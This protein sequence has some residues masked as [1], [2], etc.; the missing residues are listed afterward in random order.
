VRYVRVWLFF[1]KTAIIRTLEFR[2]DF[3]AWTIINLLWMVFQLTFYWVIYQHTDAIAGWNADQLRVLLG[4][5]YVLEFGVWTFG[6]PNLGRISGYVN[7]GELDLFLLKPLNSQFHVSLKR[8]SPHNVP[9]IIPASLLVITG[10]Q[11]LGA[12]VDALTVT[13]YLALVG[14]GMVIFYALWFMSVT[15]VI[16]LQR[17]TNIQ[18][19]FL[20]A[21]PAQK[22]PPEVFGLL[23]RFVLTF[24]LP[25][26]MVTAFPT[27][28]AMGL[29]SPAMAGVMVATA[30]VL[31]W[32]SGRLWTFALRS[33]V[34]ASS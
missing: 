20:V 2:A 21:L 24:V 33:Y 4:T 27:Q 32:A 22:A 7:R 17:C 13:L 15:S 14:A 9:G 23:G 29:L 8:M 30:A 6:Y 31:L 5:C 25:V 10:L 1:I 3:V 11:A 34:S 12:R 18:E 26:A 16:W 28:A 19:L